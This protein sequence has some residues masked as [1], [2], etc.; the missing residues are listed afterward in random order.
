MCYG[1]CAHRRMSHVACCMR[2]QMPCVRCHGLSYA[3][4]L[5]SCHAMPCHIASF[6]LSTISSVCTTIATPSRTS[7]APTYP[8]QPPT[9]NTHGQ[10]LSASHTPPMQ[11]QPHIR[12]M[13]YM[14]WNRCSISRVSD[15]WA[16]GVCA[17][18]N[19]VVHVFGCAGSFA[20]S[21][22]VCCSLQRCFHIACCMCH[23]T[24]VNVSP[25]SNSTSSHVP[26]VTNR[27]H[28]L[29]YSNSTIFII[30]R[31]SC[32]EWVCCVCVCVCVCVRVWRGCECR[33]C[34]SFGA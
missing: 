21:Y 25:R 34:C 33:M 9:Y 28:S 29:A 13:K 27:A 8:H 30:S 26:K 16:P 18:C 17:H 1:C 31:N 15:A 2:V 4:H 19:L 20:C 14:R 6:R 11:Q 22:V 3:I 23:V 7:P 12:H 32:G 5:L 24:Q 10:H